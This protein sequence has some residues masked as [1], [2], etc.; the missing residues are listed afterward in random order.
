MESFRGE[1]EFGFYFLD[2]VTL[3]GVIRESSRFALVFE[4]LLAGSP[5]AKRRRKYY[6][7]YVFSVHEA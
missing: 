5:S 2:R 6:Y 3:L 7:D 1:G 4:N